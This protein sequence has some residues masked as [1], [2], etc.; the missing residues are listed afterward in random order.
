[1]RMPAIDRSIVRTEGPAMIRQ[2]KEAV[3]P[4]D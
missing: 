3:D 1:M 2:W 4:I